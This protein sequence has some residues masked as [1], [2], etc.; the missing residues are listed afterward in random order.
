MNL[1]EKQNNYN[2]R[3]EANVQLGG[4]DDRNFSFFVDPE[5]N[6][7]KKLP[8]P[9]A[10]DDELLFATEPGNPADQVQQHMLRHF[11]TEEGEIQLN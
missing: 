10:D 4:L 5:A 3:N 8:P 2:T 1:E 6:K 11:A 7:K 9:I